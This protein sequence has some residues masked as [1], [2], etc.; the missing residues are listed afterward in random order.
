[1]AP[2]KGLAISGKKKNDLRIFLPGN[3]Y[4]INKKAREMPI[5]EVE[6]TTAILSRKLL[7]IDL[8]TI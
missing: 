7:S 5:A 1:M 2:T 6:R 8:L 3:L 4:L